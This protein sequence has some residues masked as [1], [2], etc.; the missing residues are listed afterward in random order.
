MWKMVPE[1]ET[2]SS[3]SPFKKVGIPDAIA[4]AELH[5]CSVGSLD[6]RRPGLP[7]A[8]WCYFALTTPASGVVQ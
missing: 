1:E 6:I 4:D 8:A 2:D 3:L 7:R 5:S